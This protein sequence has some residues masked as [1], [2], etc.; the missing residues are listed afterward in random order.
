MWARRL[1]HL[2]SGCVLAEYLLLD[3]I[4]TEAAEDPCGRGLI[5]TAG[6]G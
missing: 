3:V 2:P 6:F 5:R 4:V 1:P